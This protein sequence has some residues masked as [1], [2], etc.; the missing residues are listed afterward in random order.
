M[1][2]LDN[3]ISSP[4]YYFAYGSNLLSKRIN[5]SIANPQ[6]VCRGLLKVCIFSREKKIIKFNKQH[7]LDSRVM[8]CVSVEMYLKHGKD[9][10]LI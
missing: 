2:L 1:N 7:R 4:T 8:S 9:R 6:L 3:K 5:E 10:P